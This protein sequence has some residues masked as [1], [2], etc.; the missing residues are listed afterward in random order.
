MPEYIFKH[1][2]NHGNLFHPF[3]QIFLSKWR[4]SNL[5]EYDFETDE[6]VHRDASGNEIIREKF[7]E[8]TFTLSSAGEAGSETTRS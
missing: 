2:P 5:P 8:M 6:L 7:S 3:Y 1:S 4:D